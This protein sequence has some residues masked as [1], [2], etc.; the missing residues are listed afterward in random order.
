MVIS[1]PPAIGPL[2]GANFT[3]GNRIETLVNGDRFFPA[4]LKAIHEAKHTITLET[5][6]W[7]PGK[8]SDQFIDA[9][10]E[11]AQA[12][13]LGLDGFG[14]AAQSVQVRRRVAVAPG[15]VGDDV[16]ALA[17]QAVQ[18]GEVGVHR[19]GGQVSRT[20]APVQ[21]L[22]RRVRPGCEKP[23]GEISPQGF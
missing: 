21:G 17:Q 16:E 5:Y 2:L 10:C 6:I 13:V 7:A 4:M 1:V 9:L 11:R 18:E 22:S 23:C 3:G 15:V 12:G 20:S 19:G 8:I 14:N